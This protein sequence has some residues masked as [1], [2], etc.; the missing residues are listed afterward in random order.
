[1]KRLF[2]LVIFVISALALTTGI[3][4]YAR[5]YRPNFKDKTLKPTGIVSIKSQPSGAAIYINGE[6]KGTTDADIADLSPGK[7]QIKITKDGFS[8]WEKEISVKKEVVNLVEVV[9]FPTAPSLQALTFTGVLNPVVSP[10]S[11]KIIFALTSPRD[12]AG[13][14][15]FNLSSNPLPLLSSKTLN[16][17]ASDTSQIAFSSSTI[18]FS[19]DGKQLLAEISGQHMFFLLDS[20]KENKNPKEVTLDLDKIRQDWD[21]KLTSDT[22]GWLKSLGKEAETAAL[23]LTNLSFS[24]DKTKFL[25]SRADGSTV[26]FDSKPEPADSQKTALIN[27]PKA[28]KYLWYPDSRHVIL[29]NNNVISI[30][31]VDGTN[32]MPIYTGNFDPGLVDPWPDGSKIVISTNLNNQ[33]SSLPNLY[34]IELR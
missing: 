30:I 16:R 14:W 4:F 28:A 23:G 10:T 20:S 9:L 34:A 26:L 12:K 22:S 13:L 27:L 21:K 25:G 2:G 33:V 32:N 1:M 8:A 15:A 18:E 6:Q 11:D 29:V 24:A 31:E 7:Y 17:V 3:F 5:G 19:P